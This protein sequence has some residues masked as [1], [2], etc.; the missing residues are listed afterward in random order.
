MQTND[1]EQSG[2]RT[3]KSLFKEPRKVLG[4]DDIEGSKPRNK[5]NVFKHT[6]EPRDPLN[7]K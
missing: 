1:I 4:G 7:P 5:M 2:G 3:T 6:K